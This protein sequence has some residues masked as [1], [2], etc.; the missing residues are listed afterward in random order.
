MNLPSGSEPCRAP[1][2]DLDA[3]R[4]LTK[5]FF[6]YR[7]QKKFLFTPYG[8]LP[9][10]LISRRSMLFQIKV[11]TPITILR[12]DRKLKTSLDEFWQKSSG[13]PC[14]DPRFFELPLTEPRKI[15]DKVVS[16]KQNLYRKRFAFLDEVASAVAN[17]L[18]P[19]LTK[20]NGNI[21]K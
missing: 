7:P 4:T 11:F 8:L 12:L 21:N 13:S 17:S 5:Q 6:G 18:S 20:N 1:P 14:F 16:H 15:L 10:N 3:I 9:P 19:Y 2:N